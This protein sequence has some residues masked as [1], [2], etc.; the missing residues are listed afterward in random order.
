LNSFIV[1]VL[2]SF[3]VSVFDS[4]IEILPFFNLRLVLSSL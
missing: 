4:F 2:N 3:I 1:S